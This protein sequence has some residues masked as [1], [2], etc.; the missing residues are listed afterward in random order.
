[1]KI[2]SPGTSGAIYGK[3]SSQIISALAAAGGLP[4][5]VQPGLGRVAEQHPARFRVHEDVGALVVL[6]L[7]REVLGLA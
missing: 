3:Q 5:M 7:E 2:I 6:D 1:M 4:V